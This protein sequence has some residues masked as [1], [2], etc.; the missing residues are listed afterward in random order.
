MCL[1]LALYLSIPDLRCSSFQKVW[2]SRTS[3]HRL[4]KLPWPS[5]PCFFRFLSLFRFAVLLAFLRVF[6]FFSRDFKGSAAREILASF[7]ASSLSLP[8]KQGLEGQACPKIIRS[9]PGKPNQRKGQNEKFMNFAHFCEFWCFSLAI[10]ISNF[11]SG[12]P[13][14][15]VHELTF[16]LW[17]GLQRGHSWNKCYN[18]QGASEQ[19]GVSAT[20]R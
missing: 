17:F 9:R 4:A 6:P 11:C 10:H 1:F 8:K 14:R 15:K 19:P 3:S 13:L 12:M 20:Q 18:A 5:N 7:G 16:F 2:G